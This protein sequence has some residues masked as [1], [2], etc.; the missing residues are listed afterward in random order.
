M[1]GCRMGKFNMGRFNMGKTTGFLEYSRELGA[2]AS[3]Y[4]AGGNDWFEIFSICRRKRSETRRALHGIAGGALLS[5]RM[6]RS[7]I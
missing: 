5:D 4:S 7:I 2:A 3:S 1:R 6:P